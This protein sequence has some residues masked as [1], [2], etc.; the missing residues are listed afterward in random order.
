MQATQVLKNDFCL[1]RKWS[2]RHKRSDSFTK[3]KENIRSF[4]TQLSGDDVYA[5]ILDVFKEHEILNLQTKYRAALENISKKVNSKKIVKIKSKHHF[6]RQLREAGLRLPQIKMLKFE[7]SKKLWRSCLNKN[8]R[9][10]GGRPRL[11]IEC[12]NEIRETMIS[13]SNYS[14]DKSVLKKVYFERDPT[15][16]FKKKRTREVESYENVRFRETTLIDAYNVYKNKVNEVKPCYKVS[17]TCFIN[18]VDETFKKPNRKF[19][20]KRNI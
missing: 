3:L 16:P 5:M 12:I 19:V 4:L 7:C 6:I 10:L 18:Y 13:L 15:V 2:S 20:F 17:Y 1:S 14:A 8:E 11:P 9:N